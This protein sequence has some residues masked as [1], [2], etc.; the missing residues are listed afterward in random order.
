MAAKRTEGVIQGNGTFVLRQGDWL[1]IPKQ[2]SARYSAPEREKP[3]SVPY[4]IMGFKNSDVDDRGQIKPGV[5]KEQLYD[6]GKD[7]SQAT[8]I[9]REH[10][11][12]AASMRARLEE[13][14]G[15]SKSKAPQE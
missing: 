10:P 9:A 6:L 12:R 3:W 13:L 8:N 14:T 11:D 15:K 2:G 5:P 7:I 4:A 1:F